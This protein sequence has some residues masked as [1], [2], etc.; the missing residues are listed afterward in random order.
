MIPL[1]IHT[2]LISRFIIFTAFA[3]KHS[4]YLFVK[5]TPTISKRAPPSSYTNRTFRI[6]QLTHPSIAVALSPSLVLHTYVIPI[7]RDLRIHPNQPTRIPPAT[8]PTP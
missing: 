2:I 5:L 6:W 7:T 8:V 1:E 4:I 3:R